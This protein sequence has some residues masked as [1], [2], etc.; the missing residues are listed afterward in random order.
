MD[1]LT[2]ENF[3]RAAFGLALDPNRQSVERSADPARLAN[4]DYFTIHHINKVKVATT[5]AMSI[6]K[7]ELVNSHDCSDSDHETMDRSIEDTLNAT[8]V[9]EIITLIRGFRDIVSSYNIYQS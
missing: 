8:T 4:A 5:Y 6:F 1:S 2:Y 9:D 3:I 7:S